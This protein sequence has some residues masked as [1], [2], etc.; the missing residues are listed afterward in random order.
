MEKGWSAIRNAGSGVGGTGPD[1]VVIKNKSCVALECKAW[2]RGSLSLD[3]DQY[4]KLIEW[5]RNTAFPTYVAWRMN[6]K[7]WFFIK[8][9]EFTKGQSNWNVTKKKVL[10]LNRLM[11]HAIGLPATAPTV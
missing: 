7:G 5:E 3:D 2:E 9:D 8:L 10:A 6:G 4:Q 11:E 1:L